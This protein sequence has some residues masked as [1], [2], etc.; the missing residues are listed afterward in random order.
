[1]NTPAPVPFNRSWPLLIRVFPS[2]FRVFAKSALVPIPTFTPNGAEPIA[3][4][5]SLV[6]SETL[7]VPASN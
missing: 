3:A 1:M 5:I 6:V 7:P 2:T 4:V